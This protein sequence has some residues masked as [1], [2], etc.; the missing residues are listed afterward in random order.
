MR[1][2]TNTNNLR[3]KVSPRCIESVRIC[4]P[5]C[6]LPTQACT[7]STYEPHP[8]DREDL[9][10]PSDWIRPG[11]APSPNEVAGEVGAGVVGAVFEDSDEA[12]KMPQGWGDK[13][14]VLIFKEGN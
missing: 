10:S 9:L 8:K 1:T 6:L 5:V 14:L 2:T 3:S 7:R 4:Q 11:F 12:D 13:G